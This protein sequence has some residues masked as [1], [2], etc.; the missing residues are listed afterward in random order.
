MKTQKVSSTE[1]LFVFVFLF[2]QFISPTRRTSLLKAPHIFLGKHSF[3]WRSPNISLK[4]LGC[5]QLYVF[6]WL[7]PTH[8]TLPGCSSHPPSQAVYPGLNQPKREANSSY[9]SSVQIKIAC[10]CSSAPPPPPPP[11]VS[12]VS[13]SARRY[14]L[15]LQH[16][17]TPYA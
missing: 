3:Y 4:L 13:S 5:A 9:S 7:P 14:S 6:C 16:A 17:D 15:C 11:Y 8:S 10:G 12:S 1:W 2:P